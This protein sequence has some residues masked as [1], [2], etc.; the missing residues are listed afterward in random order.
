MR[1]NLTFK[2]SHDYLTN[3]F[4]HYSII[5]LCSGICSL[6][7]SFYGIIAGVIRTIERM[8]INGFFAFIF[9]L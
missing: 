3:F 6:I 5:A 2:K 8:K 7:L 1:D 4:R 9:L